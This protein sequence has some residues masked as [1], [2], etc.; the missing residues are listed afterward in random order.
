M[1]V[2]LSVQSSLF[3]PGHHRCPYIQFIPPV[4][5]CL[6]GAEWGQTKGSGRRGPQG[7]RGLA[8]QPLGPKEREGCHLNSSLGIT[9][10]QSLISKSTTPQPIFPPEDLLFGK[11]L[12]ESLSLPSPDSQFRLSYF[13]SPWNTSPP[14][15]REI[16]EKGQ[17]RSFQPS[18]GRALPC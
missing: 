2:C 17:H 3:Q 13:Q 8:G 9:V 14:K 1:L 16:W 12:L 6:E 11:L 10:S 18:P 15:T 5:F 7:F 4:L